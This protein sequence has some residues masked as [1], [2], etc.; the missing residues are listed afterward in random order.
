MQDKGTKRI[1]SAIKDLKKRTIQSGMSS[2]RGAE[3]QK[4]DLSKI[5]QLVSAKEET[6]SGI[7]TK[8]YKLQPEDI[9]TVSSP[10]IIELEY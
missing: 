3:R 10:Q 8:T 6:K 5:Q 7:K 1:A 4:D 9:K 2:E